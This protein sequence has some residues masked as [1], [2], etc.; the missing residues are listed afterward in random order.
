MRRSTFNL[1]HEHKLTMDI[2]ILCPVACEEVLPGDTFMGQTSLLARVAPLVNPVMHRVDL[3]VHHWYVPSRI[4]WDEFEGWITASDEAAVKPMLTLASDLDLVD[5]MGMHPTTGLEIDALPV[6]AYNMIWNNFY[7][8][9]DL[10]TA[11]DEDDLTLARI[12]WEKDYF[13]TARPSAQQ[14][15][16]VTLGLTFSDAPVTGIGNVDTSPL[17]SQGSIAE[18]GTAFDQ[19]YANRM[20]SDSTAGIKV[21][22]D[23]GGVPLVFADLSNISSGISIDDLRRAIALQRFAEARARFGSRFVDYLKFLGVNPSDGRLDRPEYLGGGKQD[24]NFSEVLA[25][26]EG[27]N[28]EVGDI[29]G[30]GIAG[31]KTRRYRKMFE[32]HGWV[33]S[34]ISA[35][36]KTVYMD[37]VPRKFQRTDPMD[38]WQKELEVLPWQELKQSEVHFNGSSSTTFGYVP[39]HEEYRHGYSYVSGNFRGG[40]EEDWHLARTFASAPTLNETFVEC[41]PSDRIYGDVNMPEL[42]INA[43][44]KIT[45]KRLVRRSASLQGL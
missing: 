28:T 26:A 40:P 35:R 9:Q 22:T 33:L 2:G 7:R 30:H 31:M 14:G 42:V 13:T 15:D 21:E 37:S 27:T 29:A 20:N 1:S 12:C 17:G 25:T 34:L 4:L 6:R 41:T 38:V 18:T 32:E 39:R 8:D 16:P 3:R 24:I 36:P 11:R 5:H 23:A 44:N 45:A 19:T 10:S 43:Y